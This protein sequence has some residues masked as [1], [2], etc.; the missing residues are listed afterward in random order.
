[1]AV[2][3]VAHLGSGGGNEGNVGQ[4]VYL[5]FTQKGSADR[6]GCSREPSGQ[7]PTFSPCGRTGLCQKDLLKDAFSEARDTHYAFLIQ[8]NHAILDPEPPATH[9]VGHHHVRGEPVAD[10]GN[11]SG[12]GDLRLRVTSKVVHDLGPAARLLDL[13]R[14]DRDA[15]IGLDLGG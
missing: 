11:L 10:N 8:G 9:H 2:S 13:V 15:G 3:N 5:R 1:M 12:M 14:E 6:R 7:Q 4:S